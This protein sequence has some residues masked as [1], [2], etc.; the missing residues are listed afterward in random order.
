V[1]A[2]LRRANNAERQRRF[3]Q[4]RRELLRALTAVA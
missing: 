1:A 3:Q 2:A 4:R